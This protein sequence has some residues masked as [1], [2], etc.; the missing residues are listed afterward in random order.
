MAQ[1]LDKFAFRFAVVLVVFA[2]A[3]AITWAAP[4]ILRSIRLR[5]SRRAR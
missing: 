2:V 1:K 5:R 4:R 3:L